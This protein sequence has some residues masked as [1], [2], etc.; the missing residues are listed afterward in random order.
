MTP[1][2][3]RLKVILI[4]AKIICCSSRFAAAVLANDVS[5][6]PIL[7]IQFQYLVKRHSFLFYFASMAIHFM[8]LMSKFLPTNSAE[9][10][11]ANPLTKTF[12]MEE[13]PT[14]KL[15][16]SI[17]LVAN[18]TLLMS[19]VFLFFTSAPL[20]VLLE[21]HLGHQNFSHRFREAGLSPSS[22]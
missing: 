20:S 14:C 3:L 7:L 17:L 18:Y 22:S 13:M 19:D 2:L 12:D 4:V 6:Y 8:F 16:K 5:F 1:P 9:I 10:R 11:F 21:N 15:Q